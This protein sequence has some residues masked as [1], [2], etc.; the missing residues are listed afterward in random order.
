MT[1]PHYRCDGCGST[2]S[3]TSIRYTARCRDCGYGLTRVATSGA[4][5]SSVSGKMAGLPDVCSLPIPA[6]CVVVGR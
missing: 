5:T 6:P 2:W 3:Y 1:E 4:G